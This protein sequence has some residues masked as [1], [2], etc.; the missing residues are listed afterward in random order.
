MIFPVATIGLAEVATALATGG[1][2]FTG[3][4]VYRAN[5]KSKALEEKRLAEQKRVQEALEKTTATADLAKIEVEGWK[6]LIET[7][8]LQYKG[9]MEESSGLRERL[10]QGNKRFEAM[11]LTLVDARSETAEGLAIIRR[12]ETEVHDLRTQVSRLS[13]RLQVGAEREIQRVGREQDR[14]RTQMD[15]PNVNKGEKGDAGETGERGERGSAGE[16]SSPG[17]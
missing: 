2:A 4:L 3:Y 11:T 17:A 16:R 12:L 6:A 14:M 1:T 10:A 7:L 13:E 5:V 8:T 15:A 9:A